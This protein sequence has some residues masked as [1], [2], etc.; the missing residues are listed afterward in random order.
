MSAGDVVKQITD[1]S[2]ALIMA[3]TNDPRALAEL[4]SQFEKISDLEEK[5]CPQ[6]IAQ[7]AA[8][9]ADLIKTAVSAAQTQAA[10]AAAE[11]MQELTGGMTLPGLDELLG[12]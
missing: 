4:A 8:S 7:A 5:D 11:M 9:A 12:S 2:Q 6:V 1:V 10:Q 3:D